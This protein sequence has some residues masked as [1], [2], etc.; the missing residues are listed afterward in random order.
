MRL[1]FLKMLLCI[2]V[3]TLANV[4]NPVALRDS[5]QLIATIIHSNIFKNNSRITKHYL[6][7]IL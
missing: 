2:I 6:K 4:F 7:I 1:L 3:A 5:V